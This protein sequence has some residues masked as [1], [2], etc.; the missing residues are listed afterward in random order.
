[1]TDETTPRG[2]D[3]Q[4]ENENAP[5]TAE[6]SVAKVEPAE[7]SPGSPTGILEE[8]L[9]QL[10]RMSEQRAQAIQRQELM[11]AEVRKAVDR[12]ARTNRTILFVAVLILVLTAVGA[13]TLWRVR[14]SQGTTGT[15]LEA[16]AQKA[17]GTETL[18]RQA[19]TQQT[20]KLDEVQSGLGDR[21]NDVRGGLVDR[22]DEV[23]DGLTAQLSVSAAALREERDAVQEEVREVLTE[24]TED[25]V[26]REMS[27]KDEAERIKRDAELARQ[28]RL[29]IIDEA[30]Q[31]LSAMAA[32]LEAPEGAEAESAEAPPAEEP[33]PEEVP[34]EDPETEPAQEAPVHEI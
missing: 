15:Q 24:R 8:A 32:S 22:M 17:D 3:S 6:S 1:M 9:T 14:T 7:V 20:R 4:P 26:S 18:V 5:E 2:E 10:K 21:L 34:A 33:A 31:R 29:K 12:Q 11:V 25:I 19:A 27:L 30:I 16:L 28:E 13:I 23:E